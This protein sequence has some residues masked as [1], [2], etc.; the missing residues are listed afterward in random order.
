MTNSLM[1]R[2]ILLSKTLT[3]DGLFCLEGWHIYHNFAQTLI[4]VLSCFNREDSL[5]GRFSN[6]IDSKTFL[7]KIL[8]L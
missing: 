4:L 1:K 3:E 2:F 6:S 7:S 5:D 8:K